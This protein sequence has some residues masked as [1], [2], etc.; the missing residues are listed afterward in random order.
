MSSTLFRVQEHTLA[1]SHIREYPRATAEGQE[2]VLQLVVKQYSPRGTFNAKNQVTIIGA[3]ANAFPKE[4]YEPL[5][6]ELYQ[7]LK[8]KGIRISNIFI[9]DVAH[10]G[11]SGIV[12]EQKLGNDP[13]WMD[14]SRDL[15]LMVNHFRQYM[16][17]PIIGVG[18]SMG[19]ANLV[20]LSLIHPRLFTSLVLVD[21]VMTR[22]PSIQGNF[23]PARA[24]TNR[25]DLWPSR[26]AAEASFKRSKFYQT[27]DPRVLDLWVQYGLRQLPTYIHPHVTPASGT[28][29]IITADPS[30]ATIPPE[31]TTEQEVTLATTK[32]QEVFQFTRPNYVTEEYP[33]PS[34]QPNP[35]THPDVD[36]TAGPNEPFYR[37][38]S[39]ATFHK[40]QYLRPSV[41]YIFADKSDLCTP[42]S[43][44]DKLAQT[45]VGVG[46]S[47]GV[48][49]GRVSA[50]TFK[51]VG[52]LIPMEVVDETAEA[53]ADWVEKE[54]ERWR[55]LEDV[56][57]RAWAAVPREQKS[58]LSEEYQRT[59]NGDWL[60]TPAELERKGK[61]KI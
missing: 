12:N 31:P 40:L 11:A 6:D 37:P 25:R 41:F 5:W 52:H 3:H 59:M 50:V 18:H 42:L 56:E 43:I 8:A 22:L 44:A 45:G 39:H 27:W 10:Q 16:K 38:E 34:T 46:G 51:G 53:S 61:S 15:F 19:G 4:L 55:A 33:S 14:H 7:R 49:K 58:V 24:S 21:P 48:K 32:H 28:P 1:S 26:K 23:F 29:P 17:R 57:R 47:G 35:V 9:A 2:D 30:T 54:V 60:K 13:S 20:N 36:P